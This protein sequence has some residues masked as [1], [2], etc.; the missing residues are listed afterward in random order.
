M[1]LRWRT[2]GTLTC[3]AKCGAEKDDTYINDRLHYELAVIQKI[4]VPD[5]NEETN[6]LWYWLHGE[7][8]ISE[9]ED[10]RVRNSPSV[11]VIK[12]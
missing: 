9:H 4:V 8:N 6:G 3:A 1:S 2:N 7:C 10:N 11:R 12:P 5:I